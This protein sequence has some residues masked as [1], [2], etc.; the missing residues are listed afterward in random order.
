MHL[1]WFTLKEEIK[2]IFQFFKTY[3]INFFLKSFLSISFPEVW[4][5]AFMMKLMPR[6]RQLRRNKKRVSR[7]NPYKSLSYAVYRIWPTIRGID[8]RAKFCNISKRPNAVPSNFGLTI[9]GSV[10]MMTEQNKPIEI[11]I[12]ETG[13]HLNHYNYLRDLLV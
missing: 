3:L 5:T 6:Q 2:I 13:T 12:K 1:F 4:S 8:P 11:P 9:I 10:G 7:W